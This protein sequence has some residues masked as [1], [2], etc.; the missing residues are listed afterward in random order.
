MTAPW[1]WSGSDASLPEPQPG[2]SDGAAE[3]LVVVPVS[4]LDLL[5]LNALARAASIGAP[6]LAVHV[7]ADPDEAR[8]FLRAWRAWGDRV[9]LEL[10][11]SP[12]RAIVA[13]LA[14][15]LRDLHAANPGTRITVLLPELVV[16]NPLQRP[17]HNRHARHLRRLLR[18][19]PGFTVEAFP[20]QPPR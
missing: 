11:R 1:R 17:L 8:A 16:A 13:P 10:V 19:E 9:P 4:R 5:R 14:R 7:S 6:V 3:R 18:E 20:F 15:Y 12:Y 2:H